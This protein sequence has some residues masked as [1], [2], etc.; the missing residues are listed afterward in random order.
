[1]DH[2]FVRETY[3]NYQA[4]ADLRGDTRQQFTFGG[5]TWVRYRGTSAVNITDA[6]AY[7]VPMGVSGM[8]LTRF[9]PANYIE[10]V[11]TIGLPYY[12]KSE[13]IPMDKGIR[14]EGQTNPLNIN[15]RPAAVVK[16]TTN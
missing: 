14:M 3:L 16:L 15:T 12:A 4:A 1:M 7:A 8:F 13:K 10:T 9:A 5:V 2:P 11:N 6:E